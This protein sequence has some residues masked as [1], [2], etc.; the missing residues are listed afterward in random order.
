MK[1]AIIIKVTEN[2]VTIEVKPFEASL[3]WYYK[4][5]ECDC[6]NIVRCYGLKTEA[7]MIVDDEA[8]CKDN[9]IVNPHASIAYGV[10]EHGQPICGNAI[11]CKPLLTPDGVEEQ[12]FEP[13][14]IDQILSEITDLL[15]R[16]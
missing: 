10:I 7:D 12:G 5:L 2:T 3:E 4:E 9:P 6:I 16:G 15:I 1:K 8:L 14:E 13:D 11:I